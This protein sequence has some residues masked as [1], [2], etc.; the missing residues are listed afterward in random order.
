MY[1]VEIETNRRFER[2]VPEGMRCKNGASVDGQWRGHNAATARPSLE[3][4]LKAL[5]DATILTVGALLRVPGGR[6]SESLDLRDLWLL[7]PR[8]LKL[9]WVVLM[10]AVDDAAAG[11]LIRLQWI[12][13]RAGRP[14]SF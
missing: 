9:C 8:E 13:W 11:P 12:V 2:W 7:S 4:E 14:V 1:V 5:S 10:S 6:D 3:S